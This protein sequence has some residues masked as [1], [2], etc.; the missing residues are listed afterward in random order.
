[1]TLAIVGYCLW[2]ATHMADLTPPPVESASITTPAS[3]SPLQ[4]FLW[5]I[6]SPWFSLFLLVI[7][8]V[9]QAMG[10]AFYKFRQSFE[11]NEMEWFNGPETLVLW[12]IICVCQIIASFVRV[13]WT[14]RKAGTH[15]SH[16]GVVLLVVTCT[17]YF[18]YKKE[19]DALLVR[20]YIK[21]DSE[22]GSCR[23]LPNTG[24]TAPL[25][26]G[27]ATVQ[28]IMPRWTILS[29]DGKSQQA[30]AVMVQITMP[31]SESFTAT[32]IEDRPDLTQYTMAGRRPN[33]Y[34][35]EFTGVMASDASV[36]A[37][38]GEGKPIL[39]LAL[40]VGAEV[41][42]K[43]EGGERSL[44]IDKITPDF[45]LLA[46]G[47]QG[48][49]GT[50]VEW[51]L[52]SPAGQQSG[53]SVVGEPSLTRYQRARVKAAPDKRLTAIMLEH[54]PEVMAYNKD[55]P[56]IWI[57]REEAA[58][59]RDP[60]V[61]F[62]SVDPDAVA[63]L[64]I[65]GLPR[66]HDYGRHMTDGKPLAIAIGSVNGVDFHITGFSP[67]AR[68][69]SRWKEDKEAVANPIL[70]VR[71]TSS[72]D[73][74]GFNRVVSATTD[75]SSLEDTPLLWLHCV[76]EPTYQKAL[77][78]LQRQFP[79]LDQESTT[80]ADPADQGLAAQ[81]RL[82]FISAPGKKVTLHVGQPGRNL[83]L[84][85]M[86]PASEV[87]VALWGDD[88]TVRLNQILQYP[89]KV[90]EPVPVPKEQQQSRMSVGDFES[91]VEVTAT[92]QGSTTSVW[93][94]YSPYPHLPREMG[95]ETSLGMY[96]PRPIMI[97]VPKA[98]RYELCYGKAPMPM[99]GPIWMTGFDVPRRPGS[100]EPSEFFCFVGYGDEK[101]PQTAKIH[102]NHPLE[103][104]GTFFF[105]ASWDPQSQAL[106]VLGVGNRPAGYPML[107]A[108][109]ILALGM[110]WSGFMA[111]FAGTTGRK[112]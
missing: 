19:G 46:D 45:P 100:D 54:A 50:M 34:M 58:L 4:R 22:L 23:L 104:L 5:A 81:T 57:R 18:A 111:A 107:W 49:T 40:T 67:Y 98:G 37:L 29:K 25:G 56:A 88:V 71:F 91:V 53:S 41:K 2:S 84:F 68:L 61:P 70:D 17:I 105:Q 16:A 108:S 110:A 66:Y 62:R 27:T 78:Q 14:W 95:N 9:H 75:I 96:A 93:V 31:D 32:L 48:K 7:V 74:Q 36:Q 77:A 73:G 60:L 90:T 33:T 106:T 10:S 51:T 92:Y 85:P 24:Y 89:R 109:I 87:K 30:W 21:V 11:V 47:F 63:A 28:S 44:K 112:S 15:L 3:R 38:D 6:S 26:N 94:P 86:D 55:K 35:P 52:K 43:V 82:A 97:D 39:N 72:V 80:G 103:W 99:P 83:R 20:H 64:T 76:D 12:G 65:K 1:M 8:F 102:M 42:E 13:P 79:V 69:T 101:A 59:K